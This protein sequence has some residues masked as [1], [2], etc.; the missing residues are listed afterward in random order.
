MNVKITA[1]I[2][3]AILVV[4]GAAVFM[5]NGG[6]DEKVDTVPGQLLIYGNADGDSNLDD[7]DVSLIKDIIKKNNWNKNLNPFADANCDGKVDN[8]D[9]ALT[10]N[11]IA[12]K[13]CTAYYY[14]VMEK[15]PE[16]FKYPINTI[17][18]VSI[19]AALAT[20]IL[21]LDDRVIAVSSATQDAVLF[22]DVYDR[23]VPNLGT[24]P[25]V[26]KMSDIAGKLDAVICNTYVS[27]LTNEPALEATGNIK[28]IRLAFEAADNLSAYL[29]YG[30]MT[31]STERAEKFV[32]FTQDVLDRIS[33]KT[34]TL[35]K[36]D[37]KSGMVLGYN[38]IYG[39]QQ[40]YGT[41]ITNAGGIDKVDWDAYRLCSAG[42]EW[43]YDYNFDFIVGLA[44]P[45]G[46]DYNPA[47][48]NPD[49]LD[50]WNKHYDRYKETDAVKAGNL[51]VVDNNLP[52]LIKTAY[53]AEY[54]YPG[55]FDKG[56]GDSVHQEYLDLFIDNL[57]GNFDVSK[58]IFVLDSDL[59][60]TLSS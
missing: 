45:A 36:E 19:D 28:V 47:T 58:G 52:I 8:N 2:I 37:V 16:S 39:T 43:L 55:L 23:N 51:F 21:G 53:V 10:E 41:I 1:V 42:F 20:K 31:K 30:F 46:Y 27:N 34:S 5:L 15:A 44:N 29:T 57:S 54:F 50:I 7:D 13:S 12:G 56:F 26:E 49:V 22:K 38:V 60:K 33:A 40:N 59:A 24:N 32:Q 6:S 4:A 35:A 14:N 25:T 18:T 3:V 48:D 17:Y 11:L 9:V